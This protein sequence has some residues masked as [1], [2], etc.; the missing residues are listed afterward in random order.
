MLAEA[1]LEVKDIPL[2]DQRLLNSIDEALGSS[3]VFLT[4]FCAPKLV[5]DLLPLNDHWPGPLSKLFVF[6][7]SSPA[8][9]GSMSLC[10]LSFVCL[11]ALSP[12]RLFSEA[13]FVLCSTD[14]VLRGPE[15][16][17][18]VPR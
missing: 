16:C 3:I 14:G 7:D 2:K 11:S 5:F 18:T 15:A 17:T 8:E 1:L 6:L 12:E 13:D 9:D 4:S 10:A